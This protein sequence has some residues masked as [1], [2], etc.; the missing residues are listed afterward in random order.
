MAASLELKSTVVNGPAC[1]SF[2][3]PGMHVRT[4]MIFPVA[5]LSGEEEDDQGG[6]H[7]DEQVGGEHSYTCTLLYSYMYAV[8]QE[9]F[10]CRN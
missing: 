9:I 5:I 2:S 7:Q 6:L 1:G 3:P 10:V 8:Y 4:C